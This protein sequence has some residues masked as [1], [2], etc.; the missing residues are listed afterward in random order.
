VWG[1]E[2]PD[3][4]IH[5]PDEV[6]ARATEL[7]LQQ[8]SFEEFC[9]F[10]QHKYILVRGKEYRY[11]I[12]PRICLNVEVFKGSEKIAYLNSAFQNMKIPFIDTLV[13]Q[14]ILL[15]TEP[16]KYIASACEWR[17]V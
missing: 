4:Y 11:H 13:S 7:L 3:G 6:L 15:K 14:Y 16:E 12:Y 5:H 17:E 2:L 1:S 10:K 9:F 8:I